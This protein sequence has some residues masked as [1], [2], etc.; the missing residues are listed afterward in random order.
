MRDT[1]VDFMGLIRAPRIDCIKPENYIRYVPIYER[2][3][4]KWNPRFIT[5]LLGNVPLLPPRHKEHYVNTG[6]IHKN[7]VVPENPEVI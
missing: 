1:A 6:P 5:T 3:E 4:Q 2:L 7:W